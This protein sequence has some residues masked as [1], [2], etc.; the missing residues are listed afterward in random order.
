VAGVLTLL[1]T[2]DTLIVENVAVRPAAQG[3]GV[4]RALLDF[5][6]LQGQAAQG[7]TP[8][9]VT[10]RGHDGEPGDLQASRY[11]EWSER[12][13]TG[14]TAFFMERRSA[15]AVPARSALESAP[16]GRRKPRVRTRLRGA[17]GA[18]RDRDRLDDAQAG[19]MPG[20]W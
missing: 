14:T 19:R 1:L 15:Q 12:P 8:R 10:P 17:D 20:P 3:T 7:D 16:P 4:G 5:A 11:R 2:G 6:E 13:W 18:A 9:T